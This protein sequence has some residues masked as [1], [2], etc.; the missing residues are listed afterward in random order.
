MGCHSYLLQTRSTSWPELYENCL[1]QLGFDTSGWLQCPA[2]ASECSIC[3]EQEVPYSFLYEN[4]RNLETCKFLGDK[5]GIVLKIRLEGGEVTGLTSS[6]RLYNST[7]LSDVEIKCDDRVISAH[8][9]VLGVHSD[10]LRTVFSSLRQC[11]GST[12]RLTLSE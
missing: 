10:T 11:C 5:L 8:Q 7:E 3:F 9:N 1:L 2:P 4:R 12:C 6:S